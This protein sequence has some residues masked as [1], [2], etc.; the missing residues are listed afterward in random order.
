M[1]QVAVEADGLLS[2]EKVGLE[3][4]LG[5]ETQQKLELDFVQVEKVE[6]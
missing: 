6:K 4:T 1:V 2:E 5:E 3:Y